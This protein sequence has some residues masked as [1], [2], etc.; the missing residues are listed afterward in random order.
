MRFCLFI[1][2]SVSLCL[3]VFSRHILG[4]R[5][6]VMLSGSETSLLVFFTPFQLHAT[7]ERQNCMFYT[8]KALK[9]TRHISTPHFARF[10]YFTYLFVMICKRKHIKKIVCGFL[11]KTLWNRANKA[12]FNKNARKCKL[13]CKFNGKFKCN[14]YQKCKN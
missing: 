11:A 6:C 8:L 4:F 7:L 5:I 13:D 1:N 12:E 10:L 14:A 3:S 9:L 2:V